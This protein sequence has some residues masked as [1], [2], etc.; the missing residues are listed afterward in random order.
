KE[1]TDDGEN[2]VENDANDT[3]ANSDYDGQTSEQTSEE[4]NDDDS[5]NVTDASQSEHIDFTFNILFNDI[6]SL[7]VENYEADFDVPNEESQTKRVM[8]TNDVGKREKRFWKQMRG[9]G[10]MNDNNDEWMN[11]M[12]RVG[13][14]REVNL[15][16]AVVIRVKRVS[17]AG[18]S[19]KKNKLNERRG[20]SNRGDDAA[21]NANTN[22][23]TNDEI[24]AQNTR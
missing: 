22:T 9:M 6:F 18:S 24:N 1:T 15:V 13:P 7:E 19:H 20:S 8:G 21:D 12:H 4:Q 10:V 11:G 3:D 16:D 23:S 14:Q 17:R 2:E 5:N